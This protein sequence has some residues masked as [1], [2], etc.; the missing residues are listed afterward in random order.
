MRMCSVGDVRGLVFPFL[1]LSLHE[2]PP[3]Y[4]GIFEIF[5]ALLG[6]LES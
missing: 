4:N 5:S 2:L 1:F 6:S 3:P